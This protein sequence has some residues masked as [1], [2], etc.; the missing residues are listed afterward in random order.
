MRKE[1][2]AAIIAGCL[3]LCSSLTPI[4]GAAETNADN[5]VLEEVVVSD[6]KS[7]PLKNPVKATVITKE[8]IKAK[9]AKNVA[10]ALN[11]VSGL[12]VTTSNTKGKSTAQIR[13]SDAN[14]TKIFI[15][16]VQLTPI[17]DGR[18]DLSSIPTD[19]IEKIEVFKGAVPVIYGT[20]APGGVIYITTKSGSGKSFGSVTLANGSY[21]TRRYSASIGGSNGNINYFFNAKSELSDGYTLHSSKENKFYNGKLDWEIDPK[22]S[23]T[24]FGS[25]SD[26]KVQIP[27]RYYPNGTMYATPGQ[28]GAIANNNFFTGTY[29]W[30]YD[31]MKQSYIGAIYKHKING[32]SD[33]NFKLYESKEYS[34]LNTSNAK[35]HDYWNGSVKGYEFQYNIQANADNKISTGFAYE[36]RDFTELA[37]NSALSKTAKGGYC[38]SDYSYHDQSFY[39]QDTINVC[40]EMTTAIG[41]RHYENHDRMNINNPAF[42]NAKT[43]PY[44]TG[45]Y[46]DPY[47]LKGNESA[48]DPVLSFNYNV[49]DSTAL[50]GAFGKSYKYPNAMERSGVGGYLNGLSASSGVSQYLL[51]ETAINREIG[52]SHTFSSKL[53][54]DV[55]YFNKDI[56]NMIKGQGQANAHTQYENIPHVDMHGF[57]AELHQ[58]ISKTVKAFVNYSYTNAY[59]TRAKDQVSDIP[60]RKFSYGFNY[61]DKNGYAAN[62]AVNYIGSVR[63]V[64]SNGNGNSEGDGNVALN[65]VYLPSYHVVDCKIS[66]TVNNTEYYVKV[67]NLL[68]K[69]YYLGAYLVAPERYSEVGMTVKL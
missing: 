69:K 58:K 36:T 51:P 22:S 14:N 47:H 30:E 29:N 59:D 66:K 46:V 40:R 34:T 45:L 42:F 20:D 5:T 17:G 4:A 60:Y 25:Y 7:K 35:L 28:G 61:E 15:D 62:L 48:N 8:D 2:K 56:D 64:F 67:L 37:V 49:T 24:F 3:L 53:G 33:F 57:E 27:N 32:K 19:I 10:E 65:N 52:L 41:F 31:P 39:I 44:A 43:Y 9:G 23:L 50:H 13:G 12:Y 6:T 26:T 38:D 55:T 18:V 21:D 1:K 68:D 16:G 11:D 54:F 63:S